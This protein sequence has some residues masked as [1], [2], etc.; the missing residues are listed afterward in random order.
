[1]VRWGK[2][3]SIADGFVVCNFW[4]VFEGDE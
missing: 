4:Y 1:M 3:K 2:N